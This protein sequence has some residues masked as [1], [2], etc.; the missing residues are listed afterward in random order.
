VSEEAMEIG[1][2]LG[3]STKRSDVAKR[4]REIAK[5]KGKKPS[6]IIEEAIS[7]YEM[8]DMMSNVDS[9]C[10]VVGLQLANKVLENAVSVLSNVAKLFTSEMVSHYLGAIMKGYEVAK[11]SSKQQE[12]SLPQDLRTAITQTITPIINLA[13]TLLTTIMTNVISTLTGGKATQTA[14]TTTS[15]TSALQTSGVKIE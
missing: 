1:R 2:V 11:E 8:M 13:T 5:Q 10:L 4:I 12:V 7:I 14:I 9:R 3:G 6:E 15:T